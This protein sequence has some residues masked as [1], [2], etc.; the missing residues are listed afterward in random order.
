MKPH[1]IAGPAG[2][3]MDEYYWMRD[4]DPKAKR[5]EIIEHLKAENA[6]TEAAMAPLEP[7][8]QALVAE[9]RARIKEDD[10]SVP[11]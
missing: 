1:D 5:P 7:L 6:Y 2:V 4:D 3:R 9:M 8:R 10:S 11:V